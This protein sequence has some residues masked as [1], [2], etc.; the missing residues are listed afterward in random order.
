MSPSVA[1]TR[2]ILLR[3]GPVCPSLWNGQTKPIHVMDATSANAGAGSNVG[4]RPKATSGDR[5]LP[6]RSLPAA[7]FIFV[8]WHSASVREVCVGSDSI[9]PPSAEPVKAP[10]DLR[11]GYLH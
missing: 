4:N 5:H 6:G 7:Y 10:F 11:S 9:S 2:A 1:A 3:R 8:N